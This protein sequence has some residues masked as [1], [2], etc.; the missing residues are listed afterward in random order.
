MSKIQ[1]PS[2][3]NA[4]FKVDQVTDPNGAPRRVLDLD[5]DFAVKGHIDFPAWM[6][7]TGNFSIYADQHGGGYNEKILSTDIT[8]TATGTEPTLTT[9][10][11]QANY[12][13][14]LP[15]GSTPLTDPSPAPSS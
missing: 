13:S 3:E 9:Y 8:I 4:D 1:F 11:W 7:G 5:L 2:T 15:T 12:P 14:D 6:S 10:D